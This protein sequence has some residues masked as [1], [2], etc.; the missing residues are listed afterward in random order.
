M[1]IWV[2]KHIL[3]LSLM[4]LYQ[5]LNVLKVEVISF[6][7][8]TVDELICPLLLFLSLFVSAYVSLCTFDDIENVQRIQTIAAHCGQWRDLTAGGSHACHNHASTS[9]RDSQIHYCFLFRFV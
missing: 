9:A 5:S 8:E 3:I 2:A 7:G 1:K 6:A 4:M